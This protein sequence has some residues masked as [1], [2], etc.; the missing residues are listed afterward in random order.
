MTLSYFAVRLLDKLT[1]LVTNVKLVNKIQFILLYY[2]IF[3]AHRIYL[4]LY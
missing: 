3:Y 1:F 4:Y 2:I